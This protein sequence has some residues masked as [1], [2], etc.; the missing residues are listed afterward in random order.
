[1]RTKNEAVCIYVIHFLVSDRCSNFGKWCNYIS[2]TCKWVVSLLLQT[3]YKIAMASNICYKNACLQKK[4]VYHDTQIVYNCSEVES[5]LKNI[6]CTN[7]TLLV[8][9][10]LPV[11]C[12]VQCADRH[13][14][15]TMRPLT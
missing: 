9:Y 15:I 14:D 6:F 13:E 4:N 3:P 10:L 11:T 5:R 1:M 12:Q 8:P 7:L 2:V